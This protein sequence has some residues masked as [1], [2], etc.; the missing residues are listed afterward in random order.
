MRPSR[1]GTEGEG[2]KNVKIDQKPLDLRNGKYEDR[3]F[4]QFLLLVM[5]PLIVMGLLSYQIY[6]QGET[7]RN[8]QALDSYGESVSIEY[9]NLF[10]S[11]RE[12]YLDSTS[13]STFKWL[14]EQKDPDGIRF[15]LECTQ[16]DRQTLTDA[17]ALAREKGAAEAL[18]LL[19]EE[20][21]RRFDGGT[22]KEFAL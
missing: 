13:N 3:L 21:H 4:L 16:P 9:D 12:Y 6:V 11:I 17:C 20:Q 1:K 22:R 2:Q 8:R 10:S 14:L 7:R 15:L 5:V 18:A 19:L